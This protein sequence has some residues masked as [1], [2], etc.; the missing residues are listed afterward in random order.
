[1]KYAVALALLILA[2]AEL[3]SRVLAGQEVVLLLPLVAVVG[4]G[5]GSAG[6]GDGGPKAAAA[7]K[8]AYG[9]GCCGHGGRRRSGERGT[10][11]TI[12]LLGRGLDALDAYVA[13]FSLNAPSRSSSRSPWWAGWRSRTGRRR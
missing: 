3:L 1:M 2:Q 5:P 13:G 4:L 8:E 9:S 12:T 10:G 7:L 11:Q 6:L